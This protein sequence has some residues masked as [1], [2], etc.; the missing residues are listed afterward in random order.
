MLVSLGLFPAFF[1]MS[2]ETFPSP[3]L[4]SKSWCWNSQGEEGWGLQRLTCKQC[5]T[6][7]FHFQHQ[8]PASISCTPQS[9]DLLGTLS[10]ESASLVFCCSWKGQ[11]LSQW[12]GRQILG[13]WLLPKQIFSQ[14]SCTDITFL[15]LVP[16]FQETFSFSDCYLFWCK[17]GCSLVYL[18]AG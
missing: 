12:N 8:S 9:Q 6:K 15:F 18:D 17:L 5:F 14:F 11:F 2:R 1:R 10:K 13:V 16:L 4:I 3:Y 7:P